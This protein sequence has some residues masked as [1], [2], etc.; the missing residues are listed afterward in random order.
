MTANESDL[1]L[2]AHSYPRTAGHWGGDT[3]QA[4]AEQIEG[5]GKAEALRNRIVL[6]LGKHEDGLTADEAAE[7]LGEIRD[8]VRPRFTELKKR[9]I[10]ID[11]GKRRES[12]N[13]NKQRVL[14]LS[15]S[16]PVPEPRKK[17]KEA[18][19]KR[20]ATDFFR[21]WYNQPGTNTDDGFDD[22]WKQNR[23]KYE[24]I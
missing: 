20:I 17:K 18:P 4:A 15:H 13:R 8:S 24:T 22:W 14:K 21:W 9:G 7:T 11:T 19:I 10:L 3:D 6:L 12:S 1:P 5:S 16:E 23:E 2:F